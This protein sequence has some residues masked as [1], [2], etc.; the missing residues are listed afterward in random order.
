M[1]E[2]KEKT[3]YKQYSRLLG[4]ALGLGLWYLA[5]LSIIFFSIIS[6]RS[7]LFVQET[8]VLGENYIPAASH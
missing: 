7:I 8:G 5:P 6:W 3:K 1:A 2:L 4:I